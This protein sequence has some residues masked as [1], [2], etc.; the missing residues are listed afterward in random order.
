MVIDISSSTDSE[1]EPEAKW[2]ANLLQSIFSYVH[3]SSCLSAKK[4]FGVKAGSK[5]AFIS[6]RV[7]VAELIWA[8]HSLAA[9]IAS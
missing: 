5:P 1:I 9:R 8:G 6:A 4:S 2:Y 7:R 3:C